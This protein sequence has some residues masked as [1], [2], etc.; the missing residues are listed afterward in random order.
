MTTRFVIL[1]MLIAIS[2]LSIRR[3]PRRGCRLQAR[4]RRPA[5]RRTQP[6]VQ[7]RSVRLQQVGERLAVAGGVDAEGLKRQETGVRS[8]ELRRG[9]LGSWLQTPN[10]ELYSPAHGTGFIHVLRQHPGT[11]RQSLRAYLGSAQDAR[12]A[13]EL[14]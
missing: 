11:N 1:G 10:S 7:V 4:P 14:R 3:K 6:V 9:P 8:Q 12:V 2:H 13:A 5:R